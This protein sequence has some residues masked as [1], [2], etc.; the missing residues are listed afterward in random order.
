MRLL[1]TGLVFLDEVRAAAI[2]AT[3]RDCRAIRRAV[4]L[5]DG[6]AES[7]QETRLRLLIRRSGRPQPTAQYRI[8]V[9]GRFVARPDLAWPEHRLA[10]EYD[11]AWHGEPSQF[12]RDRQRLNRLTAPGWRVLFVTAAD[13]RGTPPD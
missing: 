11:G 2:L 3:G 10:L 7:P 6:L 5:A 8:R 12:R 1:S 9:Q 4:E 13:L